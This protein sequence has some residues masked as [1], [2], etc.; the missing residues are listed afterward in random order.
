[1][2]E[3]NSID[4]LAKVAHLLPFEVLQDID[5]RIGDWLASGEDINDQYVINQC[6]YAERVINSL[7]GEK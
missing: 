3:V 2:I 4:A 5:K 7:R 1:M 6:K